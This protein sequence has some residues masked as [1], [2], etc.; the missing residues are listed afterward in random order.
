MLFLSHSVFFPSFVC[1]FLILIH[2][3]SSINSFLNSLFL[4]VLLK[5]RF[6]NNKQFIK[7]QREPKSIIHQPRKRLRFFIHGEIVLF[8][9]RSRRKSKHYHHHYHHQHHHHLCLHFNLCPL[10][11]S[12]VGLR[13][14]WKSMDL[15]RSLP[16]F[17]P[18]LCTN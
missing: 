18:S 6:Q 7:R 17:L 14:L 16:F 12:L 11:V 3:S 13:A 9:L 10:L 5:I 2:L 4:F 8:L 15:I 1:L